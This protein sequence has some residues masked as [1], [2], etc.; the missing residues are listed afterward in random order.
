M[1]PVWGLAPAARILPKDFARREQDYEE[2][3]EGIR[4]LLAQ[5][6]GIAVQ[7]DP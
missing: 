2:G 1:L 3:T 7:T 5:G 6:N 4:Q